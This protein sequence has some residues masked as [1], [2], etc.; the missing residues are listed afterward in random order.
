MFLSLPGILYDIVQ[1]QLLSTHHLSPAILLET[2]SLEAAK[3]LTAATDAVM[4]CP[5]VYITQS[6]D[7]R[8]KVKCFRMKNID[9]MRHFFLSYQ[10]GVS[11]PRFMADFIEIV[12]NTVE[13]NK[14]L[15]EW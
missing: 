13:I 11:L 3:R 4:L 5:Y 14:E 2:D 15:T 7:I 9:Y 12:K 8:K 10:K 1:D 6:P